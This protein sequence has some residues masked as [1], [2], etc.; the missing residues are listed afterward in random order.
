MSNKFE[1]NKN[2]RPVGWDGQ[3]WMYYK[4]MMLIAFEDKSVLAYANAENTFA[5][6]TTYDEKRAFDE[7]QAKVNQIIMA[8]HS[9]E[10]GQRVWS[11]DGIEMW[12]YLV[13]LYEGIKNSATRTNQETVLCNKL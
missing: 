1:L 5:E 6:G 7:A 2:G 8:S 10:L 4:N 11:K 9:M 3:S 12:K 13:R